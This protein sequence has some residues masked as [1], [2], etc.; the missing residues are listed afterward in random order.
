MAGTKFEMFV[1]QDVLLLMHLIRPDLSQPTGNCYKV[2]LN[3]PNPLNVMSV[4]V[5]SQ[6]AYLCSSLMLSI[7]V[8]HNSFGLSPISAGWP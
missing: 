8:R 6:A 7:L 5:L 4:T 2:L 3:D 1:L